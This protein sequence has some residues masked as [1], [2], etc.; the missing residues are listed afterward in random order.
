MKNPPDWS[1]R[2]RIRAGLTKAIALFR[3]ERMDEPLEAYLKLFEEYQG[4]CGGSSGNECSPELSS[5]PLGGEI[6]TDQ[7]TP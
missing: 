1:R 5:T 6:L 2:T 7:E 4:F 3:Q